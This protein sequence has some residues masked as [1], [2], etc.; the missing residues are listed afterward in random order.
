M[1]T[2]AF[3]YLKPELDRL[4]AGLLAVEGDPASPS[5]VLDGSIFF[6][7]GG[8]QPCD[9][10]SIAGVP[11][12][13]V[14]QEEGR[15]LH[16]LGAP[17]PEGLAPGD[18]LPLVLD[19]ARRLDH[20]EQHTGQ[21]LV[22]AT[23][24]R[25]YEA[26]TKSF[27][28]GTERC[29]I[30]VDRPSL[31]ADELAMAEEAI[32][33]AIFEDYRIVTHLCPPEDI[34][35][36]PLRRVPPTDE[37]V[38]RVVEIDGLDFTPCCGT[39]LRS[40]GALRLVLLLGAEKY[41]GMTRVQ[42]LAGGR[43]VRHARGAVGAVRDVARALGVGPETLAAE[44]ERQA[45]RLKNALAE[46]RGLLRERAAAEAEHLLAESGAG[47]PLV[48]RFDDRDAE[49]AVEAVKAL[50][51]RGATALAA[52]M[53]GLTVVA[54]SNSPEAGLGRRLKPVSDALGGKG[55]GGPAFF[56][57]TFDSPAAIGEFLEKA[58]EI[59]RN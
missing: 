6:P 56:R 3:Y 41:K 46:V 40:T 12:V 57:S 38:V 54:A 15:V 26:P 10:G 42:F 45:E 8:G 33:A 58:A 1:D 39:H 59:L 20:S 48:L 55:G 18:R 14:T 13:S 49:A 34:A 51:E 22:S 28:L 11:L 43:A 44:A 19:A 32:N 7:E 37:A 50:A 29:T 27:H 30:D 53:P 25:L 9:L 31:S 35:S 47:G 36:F 16:R 52:S 5:L 21:H 4:D 24:L 17:L 23:L 2:K